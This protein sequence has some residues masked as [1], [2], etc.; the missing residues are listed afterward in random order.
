MT[1]LNLGKSK[2]QDSAVVVG[3]SL[4]GLMTAIALSDK[5]IKVTVLEKAKEG[6]RTGAGLQ[7]DGDSFNQSKIEKKLKRLASGGEDRIQLWSSIEYR[8]RKEAHDD[9]N[10]DLNFDTRVVSIDQDENSAWAKTQ[11]GKVF[12]GDILIGADGHRSIVRQRVSPNHAYAEYAGYV[13]WMSSVPEDE[14]PEN[15]RPKLHG[16]E[17]EI[18]NAIGGFSFGSI[19]EDENGV[20]RIGCTWYDNTQTELLNRLG[21]VKGN[22]VHHSIDG[23][24]I[25]REDLNILASQVK[26]RLPEPWL[27][28]ALHAIDSQNFMGIP[29]KEYVPK[30]L[31]NN[32]LALIG[33]AAHVPA[34]ITA[35]GFNESLQDAVALNECVSDGLKGSNASLAL[36][37]YE[38]MRL[39]RVQQMVE[40]GKSFSRSFGKY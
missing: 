1:N 9:K 6:T 10:I 22:F 33:D 18:L 25:P 36:E 23:K 17:V 28:A 7:I 14:L 26:E 24:D 20:R 31:I 39:K 13:V 21:A 35:G 8:L 12:K 11:E 16:Q 30:T 19:V 37:M 38:S 34:P 5:G 2:E 15:K 29:I 4:S 40:S 3:G 32:R 27:T